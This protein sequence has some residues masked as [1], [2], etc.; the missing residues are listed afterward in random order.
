MLVH[1]GFK[2]AWISEAC[3]GLNTLIVSMPS[4]GLIPCAANVAPS[5]VKAPTN[6]LTDN[7]ASLAAVPPEAES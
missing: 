3:D 6:M 7:L 4:K 1:I 5:N 2:A